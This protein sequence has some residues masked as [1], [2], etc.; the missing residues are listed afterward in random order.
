[1]GKPLQLREGQTLKGFDSAL[2]RLGVVSGASS[3]TPVSGI[4]SSGIPTLRPPLGGHE[5]AHGADHRQTFPARAEHLRVLP[6]VAECRRR[7][8]AGHWQEPPGAL[9]FALV[10]F[11]SGS[12]EVAINSG[13]SDR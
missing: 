7:S 8:G 11:L 10:P 4:A 13:T 3:T 9:N 2:P 12:R 1:M 6:D 5:F